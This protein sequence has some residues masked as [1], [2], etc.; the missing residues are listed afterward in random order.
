MTHFVRT[1]SGLHQ[2]P[3]CNTGKLGLSSLE[4]SLCTLWQQIHITR[5]G[6]YI[7]SNY[8]QMKVV[9]Q[10]LLFLQTFKLLVQKDGGCVATPGLQFEAGDLKTGIFCI[11]NPNMVVMDKCCCC[12]VRTACPIFGA[13]ALLGS[14]LQLSKDGQEVGKNLS[15]ND[16]QRESEVFALYI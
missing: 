7:F 2:L 4:F 9:R 10:L 12:S 1:V 14:L 8:N 15:Y 13:F 6:I 5:F 11:Q 3:D 16:N